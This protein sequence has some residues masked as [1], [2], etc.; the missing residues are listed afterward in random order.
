MEKIAVSIMCANQLRLEEELQQLEKAGVDW[1]HCDVMDGRFVN[2]L[3]MGPYVLQPIIET[4][5]FTTDIHLACENPQNYIEMFAPINPN[6]ITFHIEVAEDVDKLINQIK[7][8]NIKVGIAISPSTSIELLKPFLSKIDL[9]L[10]MTVEPGFAGQPFNWDV[11]RKLEELNRL[12]KKMTNKP[13]IEVDGNINKD[14]V[15]HISP[16]GANL[17]VVGT[18]ALFNH[19]N[20]TYI[21][22][23]NDVKKSFRKIQED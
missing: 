19:R 6:Y 21:D 18:S 20:G 12:I 22:K 10:V 9:I 1:F 15:S 23:L 8:H 14:T 2:N 16:I 11:L 3:A 4:G 5:K 7:K 17:Y 13:L